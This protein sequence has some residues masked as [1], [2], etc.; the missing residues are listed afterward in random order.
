MPRPQRPPRLPL[1]LLCA[2]TLTLLASAQ[3]QQQQQQ[4]QQDALLRG[5][6]RPSGGAGERYRSNAELE[7]WARSFGGDGSRCPGLGSAWTFGRS[8]QGEPLWALDVTDPSSNSSA[9]PV[10]KLL[11]NTHGDE[12]AGREIVASLAEWLC[13]RW[14]RKDD[15]Q[16][17]SLLRDARL[18][19]VPTLNPDGFEKHRRGNAAGADLN[20]DFPD[21]WLD[22]DGDGVAQAR[23]QAHYR[24]RRAGGRTKGRQPET[25]AAMS[26]A[27]HAPCVAAIAYH[28]GA[29]VANYA[30]DGH[31]SG[32]RRHGSYSRCPD[33]DTQRML[34]S[35]Y[36][37]THPSMSA[38]AQFKGGI[39]NGAAWYPLYGGN[40][41]W[42]Y[43][44]TGCMFITVEANEQKWP[45]EQRLPALIAD[46]RGA[47]LA[48]ARAALGGVTGV[49]V[50]AA[51][52]ER[53]AGARVTVLGREKSS[54]PA[55]GPSGE[56]FR[57]LLPGTYVLRASAPGYAD[58]TQT[59][60][61]PRAADGGEPSVAGV[62]LEL[63]AL[64]GGGQ[65]QQQVQQQQQQA[66]EQQQVQQ[67]QQAEQQQKVQPMA[68]ASE[69]ASWSA[70]ALAAQ[71]ETE[72]S[73][74]EHWVEVEAHRYSASLLPAGVVVMV[75]LLAVVAAARRRRRARLSAGRR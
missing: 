71:I 35:A 12:P 28:E 60:T 63:V 38:S 3:Q 6:V 42:E 68:L 72:V 22:G 43:I 1:L 45:K 70:S 36:A 75:A 14:A 30:W 18:L 25:V 15:V 61:V 21:P 11:G 10:V 53:V 31:P 9:K 19:L 55:K 69:E 37:R 74:A 51:T 5:A 13:E 59:V 40:Q 46:H 65:Q 58:G 52:G 20:R 67:Q 62:R 47:T 26:L 24:V 29:V 17:T 56:F 33:D 23:A 57:T 41:D 16:A 54:T 49:V 4:Q 8:S 66:E 73:D 7:V 2:S 39:T 27:Q 34:A 64:G 44:N 50:D 32:D 48:L